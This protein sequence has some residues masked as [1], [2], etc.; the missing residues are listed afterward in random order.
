M[1]I[2]GIETS[3][4]ETAASLLQITNQ[5]KYTNPKIEIISNVVAS[6]VNIHR[7]Y[8]GIVPEVAARAHCQ[9]IIPAL[10]ECL[11][12]LHKSD[13]PPAGEAGKSHKFAKIRGKIRDYS[14]DIDL[15][16][17]TNGPGLITS[18]LVGLK[19]AKTLSYLW[20]KPLI[21]VNHLIGHIY[22]S[23]LTSYQLP[24][25]SAIFPAICLVVSGGH[26][27]LVLMKDF[28]RFK[29]IGQT[30][31]DAA[32]EC[33]DKVA[34]LLQL[35][36]PGG[37]AIAEEAAKANFKFKILN[38]K[39]PRPMINTKDYNFS[40]S[41]LK[42]AVF[43]AVKNKKF[44]LENGKLKIKRKMKKMPQRIRSEKKQF[45]S[46]ICAEV[47]Q[48]VIDV[49]IIKTIRAVRDFNAKTV[50]LCGGVAA[51]EELR[52]QLGSKVNSLPLFVKFLVPPKNLCTDNAAMIAAA[53]YF[54]WQK[55][56]ALQ[57]KDLKNDWQKI[58]ANPDLE[59][60]E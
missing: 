32:G 57:K 13:H 18:L 37:P 4:D 41:G 44:E 58:K 33:F 50:I 1:I 51:N 43:Y 40:F 17:V 27:E 8:G 48:A 35:G 2:L 34:K 6:Q 9:N 60:K 22:A 30:L 11:S 53:A 38:F 59:I 31:D 42:T 12:N 55:L 39:L 47:Q 36:Y 23:W 49:L 25:T 26:T 56:T 7:K 54:R 29:K 14:R 21:P 45:I 5:Y 52:K 10:Q 28:G 20:Q 16:A 19:T 24:A 15:I 3:C 46:A